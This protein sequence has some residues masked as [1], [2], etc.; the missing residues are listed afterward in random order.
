MEKLSEN[1]NKTTIT[2]K[3][4]GLMPDFA[5][6]YRYKD[7]FYTLAYRDYRVRY[8]QTFMGLLWAV[9]QPTIYLVI[10]VV[11]FGGSGDG[12]FSEIPYPL[13]ALTG[14][15][16]WS[17]FSF[18][19]TQSADSLIGN[20]GMIQKVYFPR[21]IIPISKSV[22]GLIDFLIT[23]LIGFSVMAYYQ[24]VPGSHMLMLPLAALFLILVSLSFGIW[25][26]AITIRFRDI[27]HIVPF[28]V[29][30]GMFISPVF[31]P[32]SKVLQKF[33][34]HSEWVEAVYYLNPMSGV[35]E[36][37]RY[38]FLGTDISWSNLMVSGSVALVLGITSVMF[39]R[40]MENKVADIL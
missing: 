8:A 17:L 32:S 37:F 36:L 12:S 16:P 39:F 25:I 15:I 33:S 21:L 38:A 2:A 24:F 11:V 30:A 29:Q 1:T 18:T 31:Y 40:K 27:K 5:E 4:F 3:G 34:N 35:I 20:Q 10:A 14:L 23:A 22:V 13:I 28:L 26:S 7:L 6:L 9:V 19:M